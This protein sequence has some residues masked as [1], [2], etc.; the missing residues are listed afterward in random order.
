[1][2]SVAALTPDPSPSGR[3]ETVG[4]GETESWTIRIP[5]GVREVIG[6]RL[7]RLSQRYNETLTI[8]SVIGREFELRQLAP[9]IEG[10]SEDRMLEVLEEAL[11]ARVVEELPQSVGRYQFTHALIQ[12]TLTSELSLTRRVRLH[13]R[14]AEALETLYG[15]NAEAHSAELAHHFTEAQTVLGPEKL[16]H[17]SLLAG[18]RALATYPH[19]EALAQFQRGLGARNIPASST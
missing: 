17:Y 7:N 6:R 16:V 19:E 15:A 11:A 14:I 2:G 12:E 18:E 3:G 8:A 4:R 1:M 9:L 10:V 13:A 5:E